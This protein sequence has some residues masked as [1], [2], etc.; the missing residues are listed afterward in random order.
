[1][2]DFKVNCNLCSA[3][4]SVLLDLGSHPI[5]NH[6]I[7]RPSK[8]TNFYPMRV[9]GCYS[10]GLVQLCDQI[11][12]NLFYT[13]YATPSRWK[14][15]PHLVKVLDRLISKNER[16]LDVGCND[17]KFLKNL[18]DNGWTEIFG[19]EPTLNTSE[20]ALQ[21]GFTVINESLSEESASE[22][23][24]KFGLWDVVSVRQVLEHVSDLSSFGKSLRLLLKEDGILVIEVPDARIN[25]LK[26]DY[27]LWEEHVNY[28]TP[29]TLLA[30]LKMNGFQ[31]IDQ[32]ESIFSGVC[33]TVIAKKVGQSNA[34]LTD[35]NF[36]SQTE[37]NIQI[38]NFEQWAIGFDG[39]KARVQAEV[40]KGS[41]HDQVILYGVGSRSSNFVNIM[42]ISEMLDFAVDGQLEKQGL[43]MPG[44]CKEIISPEIFNERLSISPFYILGVNA[45]NEDRVIS[46]ENSFNGSK[47][48]SVLPPSTRLLSAWK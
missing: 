7:Q 47:V 41:N 37:L 24:S 42:G 2:G 40:T 44:S 48:S 45:E 8:E 21:Q 34:V 16:V 6:L 31:V 11:D 39:F 13:N 19:L 4:L 29:E 38:D 18:H 12:T 3:K 27:A 22:L 5:A 28:F 23:V 15:E 25:I 33:L 10:C 30:F 32:Y 36:L 35:Q 20:F 43:F 14:H 46:Q 26:Q 17:G 9:A 1:M